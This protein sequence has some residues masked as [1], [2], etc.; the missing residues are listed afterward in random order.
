MND[1][2]RFDSQLRRELHDF[3]GRYDIAKG[4]LSSDEVFALW[5]ALWRLSEKIIADHRQLKAA[6]RKRR[7]MSR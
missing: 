5:T 2:E 6:E 3:E 7:R 1:S 4:E